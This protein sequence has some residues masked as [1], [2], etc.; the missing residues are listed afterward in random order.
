MSSQIVEKVRRKLS[1]PSSNHWRYLLNFQPVL[2][3]AHVNKEGVANL[4]CRAIHCL[5][6]QQIDYKENDGLYAM[7]GSRVG[8]S[9]EF[10]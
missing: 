6:L 2:D 9:P 8:Q 5:H 1:I 4:C 7:Y 3:N 10:M